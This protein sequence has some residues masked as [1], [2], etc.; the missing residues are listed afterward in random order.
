[1]KPITNAFAPPSRPVNPF[2]NSPLSKTAGGREVSTGMDS[3]ASLMSDQVHGVNSMQNN[4]NEM[5]HSLLTGGDVNEAEVLTSVQKADLAF[6]MLLQVRNKLME[7]Y[8][9]VQQIQ[10]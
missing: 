2:A 4:A 3:F 9:E 6:R 1:M 5:V 10:I 7:A 8:R